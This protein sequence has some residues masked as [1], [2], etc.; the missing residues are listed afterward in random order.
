MQ[1]LNDQYD[2]YTQNSGDG[3][4]IG[5]Y[6]HSIALQNLMA[7]YF[8]GQ[9]MDSSAETFDM[10]MA[11]IILLSGGSPQPEP[12]F[13]DAAANAS[14]YNQMSA[15]GLN[16]GGISGYAEAAVGQVGEDLLDFFGTTS[17]QQSS[18]QSGYASGDPSRQGAAWGWGALTVGSIAMNAIP[19]GGKAASLVEE[20]GVKMVTANVAKEATQVGETGFK[21]SY[22]S[23]GN[24]F[25]DSIG[26]QS[27][28]ISDIRMSVDASL[29]ANEFYEVSA[30]EGFHVDVAQNYPNFAAAGM[31]QAG[32]N[33][34][35]NYLSGFPLYFEE[36]GAYAKGSITAGNYGM[37][38]FAPIRAFG[39]LSGKQATT[40]IG[41][42]AVS[43]GLLYYDLSQ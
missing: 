35:F 10:R 41:F 13:T 32:R 24:R 42:G 3:S 6:N 25:L 9:T 43:S 21:V 33:P 30:H 1:Y 26:L 18:Q 36:I 23:T 19:G 16:R 31:T 4:I 29:P 7:T 17:V 28:Q 11:A 20:E 15:N 2:T 12:S 34:A 37:A 14:F 8:P 27:A 5:F 39:S 40:V 22:G 38:A